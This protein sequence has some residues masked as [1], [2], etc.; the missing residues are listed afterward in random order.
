[1]E[2]IEALREPDYRIFDDAYAPDEMAIQTFVHNSRWRSSTRAQGPEAR[3][4]EKVASLPNFHI[5]DADMQGS[6][7]IHRALNPTEH[8]Y[9]ARKFRSASDGAVLQALRTKFES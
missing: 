9:F 1:L 5:L 7:D 2:A 8:Q 4:G 6:V 3:V